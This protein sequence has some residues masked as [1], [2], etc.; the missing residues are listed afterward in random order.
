MKT[1][2]SKNALRH[3]M[4]SEA[5]RTVKEL[6]AE[7]FND[8]YMSYYQ[9]IAKSINIVKDIVVVNIDCENKLLDYLHTDEDI[10]EMQEGKIYIMLF[11]GY[12][13]VFD[14]TTKHQ[15]VMIT[16]EEFFSLI[17]AF[18]LSEFLDNKFEPKVKIKRMKI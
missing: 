17:K 13:S 18:V 9:L 7:Q 15:T 11:D 10:D 12:V 16:E 4:K 1:R 14:L 8:V 6:G 2:L 3:V 5:E